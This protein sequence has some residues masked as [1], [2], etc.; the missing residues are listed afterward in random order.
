L[1]GEI[2][3]GAGSELHCGAVRQTIPVVGEPDSW[4]IDWEVTVVQG[5]TD[6]DEALRVIQ[7]YVVRSPDFQEGD[8]W[9]AVPRMILGWS[10]IE[11]DASIYS[12]RWGEV[13]ATPEPPEPDQPVI[14]ALS[15]AEYAKPCSKRFILELPHCRV[16]GCIDE[17]P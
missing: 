15:C 4:F 8:L 6:C 13:P 7:T 5:D 9:R 11:N 10:C 17:L 2:A 3:L 1:W 12:C 16:Y 14:G